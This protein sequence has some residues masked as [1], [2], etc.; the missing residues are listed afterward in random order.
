MI[1]LGNGYCTCLV[2]PI[3]KRTPR[4]YLPIFPKAC[5]CFRCPRSPCYSKILCDD[6][7]ISAL[8]SYTVPDPL[9]QRALGVGGSAI[10]E[11]LILVCAVE[12]LIPGEELLD[13]F[14]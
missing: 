6:D 9:I 5:Q 1:D 4:L 10:L 12:I 3:R 2:N 7:P 13:T 14:S 8:N 11:W